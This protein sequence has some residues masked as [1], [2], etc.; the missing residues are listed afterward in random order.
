MDAPLITRLTPRLAAMGTELLDAGLSAVPSVSRTIPDGHFYEEVATMVAAGVFR[1]LQAIAEERPLTTAEIAELTGPVTE[2][3]AEDGIPLATLMVALHGAVEHLWKLVASLATSDDMDDLVALS[4]R[5]IEL[6]KVM[7]VV[8]AETYADTVQLLYS[9]ESEANQNICRAL[10]QGKPIDDTTANARVLPADAYQVVSLQ[11]GSGEQPISTGDVLVARRRARWARRVLDDLV[12]WTVLNTFDGCRGIVLIPV[13]QEGS[14]EPNVNEVVAALQDRLQVD[15]YAGTCTA[16]DRA[17]IPTAANDSRALA[18]LAQHLGKPPGA[19][20]M[21]DL[22]LEFQLTRPSQVRD[23]ILAKLT[24]LEAQPHLMEAL[25][26]HIKHGVDR[27][28][29]AAELFVHPNTLSYR[30]RR[31]SELTGVDPT[32]P[33]GSRLFAAALTIRSLQG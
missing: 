5:L 19:Y 26:I 31:I 7:T 11:V 10:L 9:A 28:A 33:D 32:N 23:Q 14:A 22:L 4:L 18:E 12:G 16:G 24:P 6:L 21:T 17:A 2:R 30:L 13:G 8:T 25:I 29:A 15:I 27:K 20:A 3:H 1:F